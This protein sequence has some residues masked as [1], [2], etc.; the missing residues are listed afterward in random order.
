MKAV[1]LA[2]GK[3]T[4][5]APYTTI[6]P[7]PLVPLGDRP[8]MDIVIHQLAHHGFSD[9]TLSLGYLAELI[10][11]YFRNGSPTV[12]HASISFVQ[13]KE[14]LGTVGSLALVPG[15]TESFLVMNGDI[16]TTLDYAAFYRFHK[17]Q[18]AALTIALNRRP[19]K[20][21][22]GVIEIDES[23][24]ITSF[25]EKP[26]LNYLVSMGVYMYEPE[27]LDY[28]E[29]GKYLDF[30]DVVWRMLKDGKRIAGY[31][32]DAYW[33]DLGSHADYAKAQDEFESMKDIL[34]P[35]KDPT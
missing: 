31:P 22:L 26:T 2:G 17:E 9:I 34:L 15:L 13:E 7:K 19:V 27:V 12:E 33:L 28:I 10:Q 8:I 29:P 14:P 25:V 24:S 20:I 5:L 11:A 3:G 30:P 16:L 1:V 21:D 6:F 32:N 4:R 35:R 23:Y 18:G